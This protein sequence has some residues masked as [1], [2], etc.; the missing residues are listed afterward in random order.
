MLTP[1][2]PEL[3][4]HEPL[5][6]AGPTFFPGN[7]PIPTSVTLIDPSILNNPAAVN[8]SNFA[9]ENPR[10]VKLN[11]YDDFN[12]IATYHAANFDIKYNG[13]FQ[14]YNYYLNDPGDGPW[15]GLQHPVLHL[16]GRFPASPRW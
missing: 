13:G 5:G 16:A 6:A 7:S 9:S 14:G 3:P 11:N 10:N 2:G 4:G 1:A 15:P 12:Y 8:H